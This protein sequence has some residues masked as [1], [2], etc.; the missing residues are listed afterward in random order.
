MLNI[1]CIVSLLYVIRNIPYVLET[2][3]ILLWL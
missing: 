3:L 2:Y 1:F